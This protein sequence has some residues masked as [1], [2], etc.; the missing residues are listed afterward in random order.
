MCSIQF[1]NLRQYSVILIVLVGVKKHRYLYIFQLGK[2]KCVSSVLN[3]QYYSHKETSINTEELCD[4]IPFHPSSTHRIRDYVIYY[5]LFFICC[6]LI[7]YREKQKQCSTAVRF[8]TPLIESS[9]IHKIFVQQ[10][11]SRQHF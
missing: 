11:L 1:G 3:F 6:F 10:L 7:N 9:K 2:N 4:N 5:L 8:T